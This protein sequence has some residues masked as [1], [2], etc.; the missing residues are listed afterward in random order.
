MSKFILGD[1]M[2]V[3]IGLPSY[4]DGYFD[5]AIVFFVRIRYIC[6][7]KIKD[8]CEYLMNYKKERLA[9]ILFVQI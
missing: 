5:L 7:S 1:C 4:P 2:D 9:N 8:V 3:E 6:S